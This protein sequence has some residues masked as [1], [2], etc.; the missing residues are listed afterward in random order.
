MYL[1]V[2]IFWYKIQWSLQWKELHY[3]DEYSNNSLSKKKII[4]QIVQ[5]KYP[6]YKVNANNILYHENNAY[7]LLGYNLRSGRSVS[8]LWKEP[9]PNLTLVVMKYK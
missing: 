7:S 3:A 2:M 6:F 8:T 4:L 9:F 5:I 1:I